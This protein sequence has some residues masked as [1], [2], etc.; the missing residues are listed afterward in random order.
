MVSDQDWDYRG[1]YSLWFLNL[2]FTF[3]NHIFVEYLITWKN[4]PNIDRK[5]ERESVLKYLEQTHEKVIS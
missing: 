1:I 4:F 5:N 3:L 2:L